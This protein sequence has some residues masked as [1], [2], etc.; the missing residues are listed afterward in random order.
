MEN[1]ENLLEAYIVSPLRSKSVRVF[2]HAVKRGGLTR[3]ATALAR[4]ESMSA[5]QPLVNCD[6]IPC[7]ARDSMVQKR[8][9][10]LG[11]LF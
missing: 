2:D 11:N 6:I 3:K 4:V 5:F 7:K 9:F 10:R 8:R 1:Y